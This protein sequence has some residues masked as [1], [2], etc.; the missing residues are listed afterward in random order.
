MASAH[1]VGEAGVDV[2]AVGVLDA[3]QVVVLG[4]LRGAEALAHARQPAS[5]SCPSAA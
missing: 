1:R 5:S 2:L 4:F 3:G